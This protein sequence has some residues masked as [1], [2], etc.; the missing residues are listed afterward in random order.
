MTDPAVAGASAHNAMVR[1][2]ET[3]A[4]DPA[5]SAEGPGEEVNTEKETPPHVLE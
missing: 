3:P 5:I 2:H 4:P 1:T